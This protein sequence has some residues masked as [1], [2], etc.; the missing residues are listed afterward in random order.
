M[1]PVFSGSFPFGRDLKVTALRSRIFSSTKLFIMA[2]ATMVMS[3]LVPSN[4]FAQTAAAKPPVSPEALA[5]HS[6]AKRPVAN[7]G[8]I[9]SCRYVG[10]RDFARL[11]LRAGLWRNCTTEPWAGM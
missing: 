9:D 11:Q 8:G 10:C 2:S 5:V 1:V 3:S 4:A 6:Q 7:V